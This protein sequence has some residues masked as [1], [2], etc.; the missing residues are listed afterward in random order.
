MVS[1]S[2]TCAPGYGDL[3]LGGAEVEE[4]NDLRILGVTFDFKLTFEM[5]LRETVS[6]AASNLGPCAEQESY[7]IVHMCSRALTIHEF[8]PD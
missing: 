2:R 8:C 1:R 4:V 7:L 3:T 6:K 5:H